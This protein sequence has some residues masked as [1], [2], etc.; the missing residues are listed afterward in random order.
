MEAVRAELER[1][2]AAVVNADARV[3]RRPGWQE[4]RGLLNLQVR[5][6]VGCGQK[7]IRAAGACVCSAHTLGLYIAA[8]SAGHGFIVIPLL[9]FML[10]NDT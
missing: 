7:A 10:I 3:G 8:R 6:V 4:A 1:A 9:A 2:A 5:H